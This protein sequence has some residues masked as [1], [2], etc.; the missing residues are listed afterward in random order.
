MNKYI[1]LRNANGAKLA[2]ESV[3][4]ALCEDAIKHMQTLPDVHSIEVEWRERVGSYTAA[5]GHT[6]DVSADAIAV[7]LRHA[8][9]DSWTHTFNRDLLAGCPGVL[10]SDEDI[11]AAAVARFRMDEAEDQSARVEAEIHAAR[12][13]AR[14]AAEEAEAPNVADQL[15]AQAP[16]LITAFLQSQAARDEAAAQREVAYQKFLVDSLSQ[17]LTQQQT[18]LM[19][20]VK[21]YGG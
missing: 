9:S 18:S 20:L 1:T 14:E 12:E 5:S 19:E 13:R 8:A 17:L 7:Y 15:L 16:A 3:P 21:H 6:Y 2:V 11:M 10:T 4:E